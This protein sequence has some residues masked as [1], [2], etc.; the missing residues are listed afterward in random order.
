MNFPS[1]RPIRS[2]SADVRGDSRGDA[3]PAC[4]LHKPEHPISSSQRPVPPQVGPYLGEVYS[5][6][7]MNVKWGIEKA[8]EFMKCSTAEFFIH[9]AGVVNMFGTRGRLLPER[10]ITP[11]VVK[12]PARPR[13]FAVESTFFANSEADPSSKELDSA[14]GDWD[15]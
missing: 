7:F 10:G 14:G 1:R 3:T 6:N 8:I 15:G 4:N 13:I 11:F 5:T 9:S 12:A 2:K